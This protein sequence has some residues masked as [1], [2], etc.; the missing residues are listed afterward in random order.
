M[1]DVPK[2]MR[3]AAIDRFG[4]P[5]VLKIRKVSTRESDKVA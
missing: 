3:A 4:R 5:S 2:T 1:Q